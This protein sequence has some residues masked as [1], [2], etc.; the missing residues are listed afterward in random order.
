MA[1]LLPL[2]DMSVG[3]ANA[4]VAY[5]Y[6]KC[7]LR[8]VH[9][10]P[11]SA[12]FGMPERVEHGFTADRKHFLAGIVEQGSRVAQQVECESRVRLRGGFVA[13]GQQF[14]DEIGLLAL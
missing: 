8:I 12:C 9:G 13:R 14:S 6:D 10:Y 7:M 3:H 11:D 5:G 1:F 4:V 2:L